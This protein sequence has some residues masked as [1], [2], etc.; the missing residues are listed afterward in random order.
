MLGFQITQG[1][2][3]Q[4][5]AYSF[6]ASQEIGACLTFVIYTLFIARHHIRSMLVSAFRKSDDSNE[7]MPSGLAI[8]GLVGGILLLAF[9]N[10]LMGMSLGF[11][12]LFV[13][14]LLGNLHCL[15]MASHPRRNS[16][17]QSFVFSAL[18]SLYHAGFG[19]N[20]SFNHDIA[21]LCIR[22]L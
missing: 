19:E 22:S 21:G 13:L 11:A 14:V 2:G 12:L 1:P 7:A 9:A 16:F 5:N 6:S 18:R 10:H 20:Q 17:C 15:D 3:V 4:W 8:T